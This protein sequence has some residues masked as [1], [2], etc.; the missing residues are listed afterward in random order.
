MWNM[1]SPLTWMV[2]GPFLTFECC[3]HVLGGSWVL[4]LTNQ[5]A[6]MSAQTSRGLPAVLSSIGVCCCCWS[7]PKASVL[8]VDVVLFSENPVVVCRDPVAEAFCR[9][10]SAGLRESTFEC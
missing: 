2:F 5:M 4:K 9:T 10:E 1:A 8:V 6:K 7:S 3:R